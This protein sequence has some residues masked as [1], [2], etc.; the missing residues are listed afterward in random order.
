MGSERMRNYTLLGDNVNLGS[1]LEGVNKQYGTN[2]IISE[3]TNE[4]AKNDIYTREMDSVRVKGKREPVRIYELLGKGKPDAGAKALI[5]TFESG[6]AAY[7][8]QQW[9]QAISIF[10]KV[11]NE[12]KPNDYA[13]TMYIERCEEYRAQPPGDGWDG[14]YVMKT[15]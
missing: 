10:D 11:R 5:E 15:K 12:L 2:I 3:Y 9:D 6:V 8:T 14:V 13:S 1:R 4:T 7:K